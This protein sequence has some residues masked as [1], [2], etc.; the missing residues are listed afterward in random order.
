MTQ[1]NIESL[2]GDS[3]PHM[4]FHDSTINKISVDFLMREVKFDCIISSGILMI[5]RHCLVKPAAY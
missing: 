3:H 1:L 4:S 2:F 5:E